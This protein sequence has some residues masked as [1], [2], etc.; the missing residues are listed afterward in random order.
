MRICEVIG[1]V[2]LVRWHP[3]LPGAS[4][5]VAVPFTAD[6]LRDRNTGRGEPFVV[7][8]TLG[9]GH[10]ELIAVSEGAEAAAAF[11]PDTK[12]IDAYNAAILDHC[13]VGE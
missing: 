7:Y 12:P 10:G 1:K 13:E 2:T 4:W 3:S 6:G 11:H 8:D 9:A 5:K